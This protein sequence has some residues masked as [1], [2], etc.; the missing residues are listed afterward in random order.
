MILFTSNSID[1]ISSTLRVWKCMSSLITEA[2]ILY[3]IFGFRVQKSTAFLTNLRATIVFLPDFKVTHRVIL[4]ILSCLLY[5]LS[6]FLGVKLS[7]ILPFILKVK[8]K[9]TE[10]PSLTLS[11]DLLKKG[12]SI[13]LLVLAKAVQA[14]YH[15]Y[16][17]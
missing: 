12:S 10:S 4:N 1:W 3:G 11:F 16:P 17:Q 6:Q 14:W 5:A 7:L 9:V 8:L 13:I 2:Q 15:L